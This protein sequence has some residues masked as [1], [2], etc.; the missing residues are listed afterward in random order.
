MKGRARVVAQLTVRP[1]K[2]RRTALVRRKKERT[3]S[4]KKEKEEFVEFY[5]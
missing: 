2:G 3:T 5:F 4:E 1:W